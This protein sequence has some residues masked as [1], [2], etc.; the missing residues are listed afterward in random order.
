VEFRILGPVEVVDHGRTVEIRRGKQLALLVYLLLHRNEAVATDR[1]ID[2]LWGERPPPTAPK[3]LQNAVSQLRRALGEDRIVTRA[4]GYSL[5]V[6][7]GEL[8]L[9]RFE[10]LVERGRAGADPRCLRE[11]LELWRGEALA[12]VR[13][14]EFAQRA[15]SDL[16]ELH[17]DAQ[18]SRIDL[19]LEAGRG[20]ALVGEIESLLARHPFDERIYSQLMLALY[21]AGRARDALAV[22][23]RARAALHELGLSPGTELEDI[24]RRILNHDADL[25]RRPLRA[26]RRAPKR[27]TLVAA[28]VAVAGLAS[29]AVGIA[30]A[31]Q[32]GTPQPVA[33][34]IVKID[35]RSGRV[36]DVV[37]VGRQPVA[38]AALPGSVWVSNAQDV[39]VTHVDEST[40]EVD[41]IGGV[42]S[43]LDI[44]GDG[45]G[46]V[47]ISTFDYDQVTRIDGRTL[48]K[49]VVV[50]L[51]RRSFLLG[52]GAGSLWVTEPPSNLG[53]AGTVA[54]VDL[55]T[56][57]LERTVRVGAVPVD[58]KIGGGA[59]WVSNGG[60]A[61]LTRI[62]LADESV[63]EI[64]IG[65]SPGPLAFAFGSVWVIAG[66]TND[67]V[68]RID[69]ETRR[70]V[71]V[72]KV[73]KHPFNVEA[74]RFGVWVA[75]R[76]SGDV[77]RIDPATNTVA[78][79][80][81]LGFKPQ[82]LSARAGSLWVSLGH[83]EL[84][85]LR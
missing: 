1:I 26:R 65:E 10:M 36:L 32:D 11:A 44:V 18:K 29:A 71:A 66:R 59:A 35:E 53:E 45:H 28:A 22:Y 43:P 38:V 81:H 24:Q 83:G 69:A 57:T 74:G 39:T 82:G 40:H 54:R 5:R 51:H 62:N 4:P 48:Q 25:P 13:D 50:P 16:E 79:R 64:P 67:T 21:G 31:R 77:V 15:A 85:G 47:W 52:T 34:S 6:D 8:D 75:L 70:V 14:E 80:V 78:K 63:D 46:H 68:W 41:T 12:N 27:R 60:Q 42:R 9:E 58:V 7:R 55:K 37:R 73:G 20:G 56:A 76:E 61:S 84:T 17:L 3:A 23:T 49:D 30:L 72:V 33:D 19:E 2:E